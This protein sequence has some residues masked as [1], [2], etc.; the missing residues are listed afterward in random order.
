MQHGAWGMEQ[1]HGARGTERKEIARWA[2]LVRR[3]TVWRE[4]GAWSQSFCYFGRHSSFLR[5]IANF[6]DIIPNKKILPC[7]YSSPR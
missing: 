5:E 3:Q 6:A 2:I 4:H 1:Q 7:Q